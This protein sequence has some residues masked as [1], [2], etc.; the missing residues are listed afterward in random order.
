MF[1]PDTGPLGSACGSL[2]GVFQVQKIEIIGVEHKA[3]VAKKTGNAYAMDLAQCI[4]HAPD[5]SKSI[6]ELTL[7]KDQG[8][9]SN[10]F[11]SAVTGVSVNFEKKIV[12][13]SLA[14]APWSDLPKSKAA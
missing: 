6:G 1:T 14:L 5:G 7:P 4:L 13:V 8:Q 9:V 11:Y 10:G 2:S 12:A 3:G